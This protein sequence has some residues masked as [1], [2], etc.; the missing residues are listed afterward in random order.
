MKT[1]TVIILG[2]IMLLSVTIPAV[3]AKGPTGKAGKSNNQRINLFEKTPS[4][5]WPIV[6]NGAW[7]K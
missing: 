1:R 2:M 4:G 6:K 7:G 5:D 3:Y